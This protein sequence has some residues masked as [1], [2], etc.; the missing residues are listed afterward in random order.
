MIGASTQDGKLL[1]D[2]AL[3][4][5]KFFQHPERD[6]VKVGLASRFCKHFMHACPMRR[7]M[8]QKLKQTV[9]GSTQVRL[10]CMCRQAWV[11]QAGPTHAYNG[12]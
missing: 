11:T 2:K 1:L 8:C 7:Q 6:R 4:L 3:A 5:M 9:E 12:L 10:S